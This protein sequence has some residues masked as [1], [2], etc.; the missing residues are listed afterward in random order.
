MLNKRKE[1]GDFNN[2]KGISIV[3]VYKNL[4]ALI[5]LYIFLPLFL[6]MLIVYILSS[7]GFPFI[8]FHTPLPLLTLHPFLP[9][10][11]LILIH[12]LS[13]FSPSHSLIPSQTPSLI[14]S[15]SFLPSFPLYFTFFLTHCLHLLNIHLLILSFHLSSPIC[16]L[17]SAYSSSPFFSI[18]LTHTVPLSPP[19]RLTR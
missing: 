16:S 9:H 6:F 18:S 12:F 4:L 5:H 17:Y 13:F 11:L 2:Y 8:F 1:I 15:L 19:Q 14:I 7:V 3:I 10:T